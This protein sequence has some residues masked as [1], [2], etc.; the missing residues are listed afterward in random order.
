VD[1]YPSLKHFRDANNHR[2]TICEGL[3][4]MG[5]AWKLPAAIPQAA[6]AINAPTRRALRSTRNVDQRE[7]WGAA[8]VGTTPAR[9]VQTFY[10]SDPK[11][12]KQAAIHER[13]KNCTG[14][15]TYRTHWDKASGDVNAKG[16]GARGSCANCNKPL[17]NVWCAGCHTWLCGPHVPL[18]SELGSATILNTIINPVT[19]VESHVCFRNSCWHEWHKH[20]LESQQH[21]RPSSSSTG[22]Q[23]TL[24]FN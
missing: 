3:R 10:E 1:Q 21:M 14:I 12:A 2:A 8:P 17:T 5:K 19:G 18:Q 6:S 11:N 22:A 23:R 20:A 9:K 15:V 4:V 16:K 7:Q 13:R 24:E